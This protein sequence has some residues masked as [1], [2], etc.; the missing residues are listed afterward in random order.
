MRD[1]DNA[2][3]R[4]LL[5]DLLHDRLTVD[6]RAE[7]EAHLVSCADCR[8]ELALLRG[9]QAAVAGRGTPAIDAAR[10]SASLRPYRARSAWSAA[11]QSWPL[12]A[13]AA[14]VLVAGAATLLRDGDSATR[15]DTVFA[16][17]HPSELSV[18]GLT[19]I[20]DSDLQTLL[21]GMGKLEAV[22]PAEPDVIVVPAVGRGSGTQP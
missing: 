11:S 17:A 5:P 13:A 14:V 9:V 4:D 12:R 15:P 10:V 22:T 19:D 18:G 1:C 2:K 16:S 7:V 6:V 21:D 8:A 20:P 3:M